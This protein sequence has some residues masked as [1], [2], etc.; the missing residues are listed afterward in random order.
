[1]AVEKLLR[2]FR[3][4]LES[5][6][7]SYE[8]FY[9]AESA[10]VHPALDEQA[11]VLTPSG[12][13]V[14]EITHRRFER[15]G[16]DPVN[17]SIDQQEQRGDDKLPLLE[18]SWNRVT[19]TLDAESMGID[20]NGSRVFEHQLDRQQQRSFGFFH[21]ADRTEARIRNVV[22]KG[23]WPRRLP[24][25]VD[26]P[27]VDRSL[28]VLESRVSKLPVSFRHDFR[29]GAPD[30]VFDFQATDGAELKDKDNG[31]LI[32]QSAAGGN[33]DLLL[34]M[35]LHGDFDIVAT[36]DELEVSMPQPR[37]TAGIGLRVTFDNDLK[38]RCALFRSTA[39]NASNRRVQFYE[40]SLRRDGTRRHSGGYLVEESR[41]GRMRV[42]RLG[43]TLYGLYA[44]GD[45]PH[46]RLISQR[47]TTAAP[48]VLN[49]LSLA[50]QGPSTSE[51]SAL[52]NSLE[53]RAERISKGTL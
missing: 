50:L 32:S 2:Y 12:V 53:I 4:L 51:V 10:A 21:Y 3:P 36:F 7:L 28:D 46:Y 37:W 33:P 18:D 52:W 35:Q 34:R 5:G 16:R 22:W 17:L 13:G 41:S 24:T 49:G 26:Q 39:R 29:D 27:L 31:I 1:M 44:S 48:T 30:D 8:F 20:L 15:F 23:D 25:L 11:F 43:K 45:S 6:E 42:V 47:E 14:H 40:S 9:R 19:L 38:H